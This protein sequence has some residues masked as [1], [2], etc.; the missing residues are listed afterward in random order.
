MTRISCIRTQ[1]HFQFPET[2]KRFLPDDDLRFP[3]MFPWSVE[4]CS[5][6]R[7]LLYD[8]HVDEEIFI[9]SLTVSE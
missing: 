9:A 6:P 2:P 1:N 3:R 8:L 4:D 7:Q 5:A